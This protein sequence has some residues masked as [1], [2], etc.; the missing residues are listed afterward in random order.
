MAQKI[1]QKNKHLALYLSSSM[2]EKYLVVALI[3]FY[4]SS[5]TLNIRVTRWQ[6][7]YRLCDARVH[8]ISY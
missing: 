8:Y 3:D 6:S 2:G 4:L 1:M 5:D 7:Q